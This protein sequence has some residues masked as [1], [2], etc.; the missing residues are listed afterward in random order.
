VTPALRPQRARAFCLVLEDGGTPY[1]RAR[2]QQYTVT[3]DHYSSVGT[4]SKAEAQVDQ[5]SGRN[6]TRP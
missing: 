6:R 1:R 5:A 3:V 2:I 4:D